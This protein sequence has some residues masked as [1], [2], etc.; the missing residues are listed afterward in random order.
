[1]ARNTH[2][3]THTHT[4]ARARAIATSLSPS[5]S[6]LLSTPATRSHLCNR[7]GRQRSR[8][9]AVVSGRDDKKQVLVVPGI[10][11]HL[12]GL[13]R[14]ARR[15]G[16]RTP[17]RAVNPR[18]GLVCVCGEG[19]EV[20]SVSSVVCACVRMRSAIQTKKR[21]RPRCTFFQC[22]L[23]NPPMHSPPFPQTIQPPTPP[24]SS[25]INTII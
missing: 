25:Q 13:D 22:D 19:R 15:C 12:G 3:H 1:M 10:G 2:T 20:S 7:H 6:P 14:V 18:P 24:P 21:N 5:P 16:G 11:V 9:G 4:H 17:R 23:Q 8:A